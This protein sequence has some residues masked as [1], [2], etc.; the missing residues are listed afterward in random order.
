MRKAGFESDWAGTV[1]SSCSAPWNGIDVAA[2][3]L[4][5]GSWPTGA[6]HHAAALRLHASASSLR[7]HKPGQ[8]TV[9]LRPAQ[10]IRL[11]R[12]VGTISSLRRAE[13]WRRMNWCRPGGLGVG[14]GPHTT[15]E[16]WSTGFPRIRYYA[17]VLC[18]G[19]SANIRTSAA[20]RLLTCGPAGVGEGV[21]LKGGALMPQHKDLFSL[22]FEMSQSNVATGS[23]CLSL[24]DVALCTARVWPQMLAYGPTLLPHR[25]LGHNS[26][27]E[28]PRCYTMCDLLAALRAFDGAA[29]AR[30]T[31]ACTRRNNKKIST[32]NPRGFPAHTS[33]GTDEKR[34]QPLRRMAM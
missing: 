17:S 8:D 15:T 2:R 12:H 6:P 3:I 18:L 5:C 25:C 20:E 1:P 13:L 34:S 4:A 7:A 27:R 22:L 10:P 19:A 32:A 9:R 11:E 14:I 26:A 29:G 31:S 21:G 28:G 23:N 24:G 16:R 30:H 33:Q